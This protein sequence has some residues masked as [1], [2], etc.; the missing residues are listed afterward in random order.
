[1]RR[2]LKGSMPLAGTPEMNRGRPGAVKVF[3]GQP[4]GGARMPHTGVDASDA[5]LPELP[6]DPILL[7]ELLIQRV[8]QIDLEHGIE[9][10]ND[11]KLKAANSSWG[12][13]EADDLNTA[14][15]ALEAFQKIVEAESGKLILV[16]KA[17]GLARNAEEII[18]RL[19]AEDGG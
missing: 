13:L 6:P 4:E 16:S 9:V 17:A 1:M 12:A 2:V 10:A 5:S 3:R 19:V 18:L 14:I 7:L 11:A 15:H 8:E